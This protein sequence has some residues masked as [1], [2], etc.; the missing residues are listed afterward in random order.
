MRNIEKTGE[1]S[2]LFILLIEL[3]VQKKIKATVH[4]LS[5]EINALQRLKFIMRRF[6]FFRKDDN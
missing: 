2:M 3:F 6:N 5:K 1:A 4:A